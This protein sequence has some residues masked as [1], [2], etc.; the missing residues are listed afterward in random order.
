MKWFLWFKF[1]SKIGMRLE[2]KGAVSKKRVLSS[3]LP[4]SK[5]LISLIILDYYWSYWKTNDDVW[6]GG[7]KVEKIGMLFGDIS[8]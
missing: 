6:V 8:D 3:S 5:S 4:I 1:Y 7:K 2:K